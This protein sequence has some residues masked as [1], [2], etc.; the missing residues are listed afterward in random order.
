MV[1]RAAASV[2]IGL[3]AISLAR[4]Q[5]LPP[6]PAPPQNPITESKRV[7]GKILFWEEQLSSDNTVACGTCHRPG[8]GGADPRAGVDPGL[9]GIPGTADD[10]LGS[11]GVIRSDLSDD[12]APDEIF[13]LTR[14]VTGRTAQPMLMAAYTPLAFW[15]GRATTTFIDPQTGLVSIPAGGAL[16]SQAVAP[17]LNEIEMSHEDRDWTQV[18]AKLA[19]ARPLALAADHPA[20][21]AAVLNDDPTYTDLFDDAFG[22]P[23]ITAERIAFAIA[24]YERTLVPD[25]TPWDTFVAG[26]PSALTPQQQQGLNTLQATTCFACHTPPMF[27]NNTFRNIGL[28]PIAEDAGRQDVTGNPADRGRFKVPT[29]RNVG[30]KR[31]FM[32]NG[33][34]QNLPQVLD[35]YLGVNGQVQF[36]NNQDP[37][38]PAI[39]IPPPTRPAVVDFLANGLTDPRVT[40]GEFP[41]DR[42]TLH[43][44]QPP[45]PALLGG[46]TIGTNGVVPTMIAITPPNLGNADFKIGVADALG[47]ANAFVAISS[48]PPVGGVLTPDS[49]EGPVALGGAGPGEGFG[50][51]HWP[52]PD[53]E[54]LLGQR[55]F[56]QWLV[57]DPGAAGGLALS[58][59]AEIRVFCTTCDCEGDLDGNGEVELGDLAALL[60]N[61]GVSDAAP[62]QGDVNGDGVVDL[63]DLARLLARFGFVCN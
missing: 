26:D 60:A 12:F 34:L 29:L 5:G 28:R 11:P 33:Q 41:F 61:F 32:H 31:N 3:S 47:G 27:T 58:R 51:F 56:M 15:D 9:D 50:T 20:D 17:V 48:N 62:E 7:L 40:A 52:I 24:T 43:T 14:Q 13:G 39:V 18:T 1:W 36:P 46:G 25:Q 53:D 2:V 21:V 38:V 35:F 63:T 37:L 59:I 6:V 16:E 4:A 45:N 22:D 23:G 55:F 19:S 30:L 49:V 44:E 8:F 57:E 10:V 42:P 54:S